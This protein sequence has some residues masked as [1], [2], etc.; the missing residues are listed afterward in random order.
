MTISLLAVTCLLILPKQLIAKSEEVS[1]TYIESFD[2]NANAT[3]KLSNEFGKIN[4]VSW[5]QNRVEILVEVRVEAGNE[6]KAQK[7]L[8]QIE[9]MISGSDNLVK[10][11]TELN[12]N[13]GNFKGDFSIDMDIK[14]PASMTLDLSNEFGD[15]I[16]TDWDGPAEINVEFGSLTATKFTSE[17]VIIN[18]EF[19]DGNIEL[20]NKAELD[21]EYAGKFTVDKAKELELSAEFSQV[22]IESVERIEV[23]T[24]YGGLDIGQAN[25]VD[26]DGEFTG[27]S[28]GKLY[29]RGDF[30]SEYG[31]IKIRFVSNSFEELILKNSFSSTKIYFEEGSSF[32]FELSSEF[33]GLSVMNDATVKIDKEGIGEHYMKGYYGSANNNSRV[34]A[35]SEY[36]EITLK[37]TD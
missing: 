6:D 9:V 29:K 25:Q 5:D 18:M 7:K 24:E 3:L 17:N 10:V 20:L 21:I 13:N 23:S 28:L 32:D 26:F 35:N 33:G 27:F 31:S 14:A 15:V 4:L 19:S 11:I 1:K 12:S 16:I 37:L 34:T 8:N 22:D 30:E 36:G 2:V